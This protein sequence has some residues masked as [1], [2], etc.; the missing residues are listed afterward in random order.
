MWPPAR[1]ARCLSAG[2]VPPSRLLHLLQRRRGTPR[3][4][5]DYRGRKG[6]QASYRDY[7][8][9]ATYCVGG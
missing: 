8:L 9:G 1:L 2:S 7:N 5:L 4:L 3:T 6:R